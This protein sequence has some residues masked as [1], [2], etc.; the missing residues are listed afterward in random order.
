MLELQD[1]ERQIG[2]QIF[3]LCS[4]AKWFRACA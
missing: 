4:Q 3:Y 1:D 2:A